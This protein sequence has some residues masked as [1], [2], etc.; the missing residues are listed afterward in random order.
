MIIKIHSKR[1]GD[2]ETI[3]DDSD[4]PLIQSIGG[5]WGISYKA[6]RKVVYVEKRIN[7]RIVGLHRFLLNAKTG[8]YVDHINHNTLDNR[9]HNL[10]IC[11]NSTNLRNGRIR[12]NNTSGISGVCWDKSRSKWSAIIKVNYKSI[13]LGRYD[14][15]E[16]AVQ[17]RK[18]AEVKYFAI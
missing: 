1:H 6:N 4:Y 8:D 17:A 3:I 5:I 10:R 13:H 9:R 11:K 16:N 12:V 14:S 2:F 15:F 18:L 7:D